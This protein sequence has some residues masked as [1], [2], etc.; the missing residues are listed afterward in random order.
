[1]GYGFKVDIYREKKQVPN[2]SGTIIFTKGEE[3]K[4]EEL[5]GYDADKWDIL[6]YC[7][8][9]GI[10][11]SDLEELLHTSATDHRIPREVLEKDI[12]ELRKE[13]NTIERK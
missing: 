7:I 2:Q 3:T 10:V 4:R 5:T 6:Y 8:E 11:L 1:M 13:Y 12:E 9:D